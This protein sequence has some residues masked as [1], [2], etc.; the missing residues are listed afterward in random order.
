MLFILS[1]K[2]HAVFILTDKHFCRLIFKLS[3][4]NM[5]CLYCL[6]RVMLFILSEKCMMC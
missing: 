4:Q 2:K 6:K 5:Q 3:E 1:A